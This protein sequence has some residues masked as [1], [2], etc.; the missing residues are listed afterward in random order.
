MW[1][2]R[3]GSER[4]GQ[5]P[6]G[7]ILPTCQRSE[8]SSFE[9]CAHSDGAGARFLGLIPSITKRTTSP[10]RGVRR[11]IPGEGWILIGLAEITKS[12]RN[13][14]PRLLTQICPWC[15]LRIH[16]GWAS[17]DPFLAIPYEISPKSSIFS[18]RVCGYF[19]G[20]LV[21]R[22][23]MIIRT[24]RPQW[25][26]YAWRAAQVGNLRAPQRR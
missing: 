23:T 20:L 2:V 16:F 8:S 26:R 11:A 3:R 25:D 24:A 9:L 15:T 10:S 5:V 4:K 19:D 7:S 1:V 6:R 22:R 21:V 12:R 14:I 18:G 13:C 17:I